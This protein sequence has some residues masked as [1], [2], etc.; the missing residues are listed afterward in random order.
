IKVE[1]SAHAR[2]RRRIRRS[3]GDV[4]PDLLKKN[5]EVETLTARLAHLGRLILR[6]RSP[7]VPVNGV[8]VLIPLGATDTELEANQTAEV[9]RRDLATVRKDFKVQCQ[10]YGLLCDMETI[11]GFQEFLQQVSSQ[12]RKKRIGQG[13]S[14]AHGLPEQE[15]VE[16]VR[17]SIQFV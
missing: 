13:F 14:F 4:L 12:E 2:G 10:V 7:W 6:A 11:P 8:V 9:I 17:R 16:Q 5:D 15:A 3:Y 1:D